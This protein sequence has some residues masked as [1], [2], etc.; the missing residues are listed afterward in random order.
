M[1]YTHDLDY[2]HPHG[3]RS[4]PC[5]GPLLCAVVE[6]HPPVSDPQAERAACGSQSANIASTGL[7]IA[8]DRRHHP[9]R[10]LWIQP[11]QIAHGSG[12][13]DDL[14]LQLVHAVPVFEFGLSNHAPGGQVG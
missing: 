5:S 9:P 10:D 3:S 6:P 2:P 4:R 7:R 12:R 8:A 11:V 1:S 13:V 14:G